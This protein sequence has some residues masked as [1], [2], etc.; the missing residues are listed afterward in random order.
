LNDYGAALET[1]LI[2]GREA[3]QIH[4]KHLGSVR[5]EEWT[6][7]GIAD[8][9]THVD[10]EAEARIVE[11][12]KSRFPDHEVLAEESA[13]ETAVCRD[14]FV[15][16]VDPLDGTT[17]FLHRYPVYCASIALLRDGVPV[18]GAVVSGPTGE[19]WSAATGSGAFRN[20]SAI[21]VSE[22]E[23]FERALIGTGFPFKKPDVFEQYI[24]QF[25]AIARSVSDIRRAGSAALDLC[26]VA[27]GYFD[28]FWE[29]DLRPWDY[30][31]GV[32]IVREAGG[33]VTDLSGN[34]PD[35]QCGGSIVAG[36][37]EVHARLSRL[38]ESAQ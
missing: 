18:A 32:V 5:A 22:C 24:S 34:E 16:V 3:A 6:V 23:R 8:F 10:R 33:V 36:G 9:V 20:G 12:I 31:A 30:A 15:W 13:D 35:W 25:R 19:E 28:G 17:N 37:H 14:G 11:C 1:A 29:L 27:A 38:L 7:K 2:A 4:Q 21:S 26:H